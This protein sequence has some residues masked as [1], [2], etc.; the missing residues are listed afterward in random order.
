MMDKTIQILGCETEWNALVWEWM[1][2][3][4]DE[5][6]DSEND[7]DSAENDLLDTL[8]CDS[9]EVDHLKKLGII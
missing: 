8:A 4:P 9:P 2:E 1:A 5:Y 7:F 3:N 6:S